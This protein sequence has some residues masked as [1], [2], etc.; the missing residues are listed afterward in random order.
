M[1]VGS[2]VATGREG[3]SVVLGARGGTGGAVARELVGQGVRVRAVTRA[4]DAGI[5]DTRLPPASYEDWAADVT[6]RGQLRRAVAGASV[7]Y[8]CVRPAYTHWWK[9]FAPLNRGVIDAVADAGAK[10]VYADNLSMYE[11]GTS[12]LTEKTP[13]TSTTKKGSLRAALAAEL[14]EEHEKGRL[15]VTIGRSSDYFGPGGLH[16]AAGA[17]FFGA[18][19]AGE[20]TRWFG[21]LDQ[22]HTMSYLPDMARAF[23]VL[24]TRPE[25]DGGIWH[26]PAAEPVNGRQFIEA[27]AEAA[28][29][30]P[31]PAVLSERSVTFYGLFL[32]VLREYPELLYQWDGPFVS[33]AGKFQDAFGPFAVTPLARAL[34]ETVAWYRART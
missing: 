33:D 28:G 23:V 2:G 11:P 25:A 8:H 13:A 24:G 3:L 20:T 34:E 6:D 15:R 19:L 5:C 30:T 31:R 1:T 14:L 7:V 27:A 10:L 4:G 21:S 9:E 29:V 22:P 16:A 32:P 17:R 26:T 12:P 18:L